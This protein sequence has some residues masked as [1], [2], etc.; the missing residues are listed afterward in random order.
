MEVSVALFIA[1]LAVVG[2]YG[3]FKVGIG[4]G[5]EGP[6]AGFFPFYVSMAVLI[7]CAVNLAKVFLTPD[8]GE[9]FAEWSQLRQVGAVLL[10]T[11]VYVGL[12]PY[13]GIYVA[14]ALLIVVFMRWFGSYSWLAA[15]GVAA[16]VVVLTFLMFE[17]WFLVPL[18]KGPLE[19][20]LGY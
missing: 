8:E 13:T 4:W 20:Y 14:S 12:V 18:P 19:V 2:I 6:R 17:M 7:S 1:L 10:P 15:V 5:A 11:A 16:V 3:S 9:I